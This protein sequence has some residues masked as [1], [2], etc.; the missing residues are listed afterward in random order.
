MLFSRFQADAAPARRLGSRCLTDAAMCTSFTLRRRAYAAKGQRD[1][2]DP[3]G[4]SGGH[5]A[6]RTSQTN[7]QS[8]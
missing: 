3:E 6:Q 2:V 7:V 8:Q 1:P 4:V 5:S